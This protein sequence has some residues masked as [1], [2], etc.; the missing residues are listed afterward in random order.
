[1]NKL[2][3]IYQNNFTQKEFE[4]LNIKYF[5]DSNISTEIWVMNKLLRDG[6]IFSNMKSRKKIKIKNIMSINELE[7]NI[8]SEQKNN[9]VYQVHLKFELR[10]INIFRLITKYNCIYSIHPGLNNNQSKNIK[11]IFGTLIEEIISLNFTHLYKQIIKQ[12][13]NLFNKIIF[14]L[15]IKLYDF[16]PADFY[17]CI[18]KKFFLDNKNHFLMSKKTKIIWGHHKDYELFIKNKKTKSNIQNKKILFIDQNVPYHSDLIALRAAD[19]NPKNYYSSINKFLE[20]VSNKL[21][22]KAHVSCHPR[23]NIK[24]IKKFFP[25]ISLSK[26]DTL[27]Q[28]K[29]A[30]CLIVH[31]STALNFGVLYSKPIIYIYNNALKHSKWQH[32]KEVVSAAKKL[33][34]FYYNIDEE[35]KLF[36]KN[37]QRE[38]KINNH[39]YWIYLKN[40]IKYKGTNK[41]S[42]EEIIYKFKLYKIWK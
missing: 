21:K 16:K 14:K 37:F 1:M 30:K 41:N 38:I 12:L 40:Y 42:A 15:K 7:N 22:T 20:K 39:N 10:S 28:V 25:N 9:T 5:I 13:Y 19:I 11:K 23:A 17:Y 33:K 34:K 4:K 2:I 35:E 3:I 18:A 24:K 26:G 8:K 31:D 32:V 29:N 6:I 27:K 36:F